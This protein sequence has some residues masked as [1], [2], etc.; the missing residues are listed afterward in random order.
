ML[1]GTRLGPKKRQYRVPVSYRPS[2]DEWR[3]VALLPAEAGGLRGTIIEYED[4][5]K[6]NDD[7]FVTNALDANMEDAAVDDYY[8]MRKV[9]AKAPGRRA[10]PPW[11]CPI[12]IFKLVFS[13]SWCSRSLIR[14][15]G[16]GSTASE[17]ATWKLQAEGA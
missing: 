13:P 6:K 7:Q 2:D 3:E 15:R 5:V 12:E 17:P 1:A 4:E 14:R 9:L 8:L 10:C 11:S 16:I